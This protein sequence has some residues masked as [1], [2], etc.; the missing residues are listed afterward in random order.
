MVLK[1]SYQ[2]VARLES[3]DERLHFTFRW[4]RTTDIGHACNANDDGLFSRIVCLLNQ[5][6]VETA[7][8][9]LKA[10]FIDD[11]F[12]LYRCG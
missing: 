10:V 2:V 11:W 4:R 6:F 3:S 9:Q 5:R 1:D 12:K 7:G 8:V